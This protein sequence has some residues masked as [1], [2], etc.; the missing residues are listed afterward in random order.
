[1]KNLVIYTMIKNEAPNLKEWIDFH[2][3]QGVDGFVIYDHNSTDDFM[4]V[5]NEY[6]PSLVKVLPLRIKGPLEA[7]VHM[8]RETM[9]HSRGTTRFVLFTDVDEFLFSPEK[10]TT[11]LQM[12]GGIFEQHPDAGG[13][14]VNWL[15]F[16]TR[17]ETLGQE[18]TQDQDQ[19]QNQLDPGPPG[20]VG[21]CLFRADKAHHVN[22]HIKTVFKPHAI[23]QKY[24]DP[25]GF[26]YKDGFRCVDTN[27]STISGPFNRAPGFPTDRLRLHHYY[28]SSIDFFMKE[29]LDR[30]AFIHKDKP[31]PE[32]L[33]TQARLMRELRHTRDASA[34]DV[35]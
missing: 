6:P 14:G 17:C 11:A 5:T 25:H 30:L 31:F 26:H 29:K 9:S 22:H 35:M 3:N 1:M 20:I 19:N 34:L 24:T 27:G 28:I 18:L 12:I 10:G 21:N 2:V 23:Q 4:R 33:E 15:T 13:I 8:A 32:V 7:R 16:G